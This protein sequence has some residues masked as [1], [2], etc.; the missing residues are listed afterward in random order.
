ME[1]QSR[2][3]QMLLCLSIV[4]A[5]TS[6]CSRQGELLGSTGIQPIQVQPE[7]SSPPLQGLVGDIEPPRDMQVGSQSKKEPTAVVAQLAERVTPLRL[8]LDAPFMDLDPLTDRV[9]DAKVV[10]LGSAVRQSHELLT[11]THRVMRF[12]I[13]QHG[14]RSVM[15]EGDESASILLDTYVRTGKGDPRA[16]LAGARPFW[17]FAEILDAVGWIR[18][19]NERN[20]GDP[21]RFVHLTEEARAAMPQLASGGDHERRL[22]DTTIAWHAQTGHRI[23]YWGGLAHTANGVATGRN[24]GGY[25]RARFGSGYVS[26]ALTFHDGS[27]PARVEAPPADYV[28]AM[29]GGVDIGP[30]LLGIHG[31]WPDSVREWLDAPAKVRLIGPGVHELRGPSLRSWFD[32]IFHSPRVTPARAL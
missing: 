14:F 4:L 18:S 29:L 6:G 9:R 30:Y 24:A 12:L 3:M 16:I 27:L 13:D 8:D 15:L 19:R 23:V 1:V 21:V 25:L 31:R 28:E 10:A 11:L 20:P 2:P 26:I 32:F 7:S 22:A 17:R 5:I